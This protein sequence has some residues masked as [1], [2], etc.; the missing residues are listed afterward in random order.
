MTDKKVMKAS[1]LCGAVTIEASN[2]EQSIGACHC[3]MCRKWAGGPFLAVNCNQEVKFTGE[4]NLSVFD[5]SA[6]AER[7]FCSA[8]GTHLYY[9]QKKL[10]RYIIPVGLFDDNE[11][12]SFDH[13][14]FIEEKPA[15]YRFENDTENMTGAE[16]FAKFSG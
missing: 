12:F 16:L 14:V 5:S 13:Q 7:G 6:W 1:C 10:N 3:S 9:R 4:S 2:M 11:A 8:C 15:Y